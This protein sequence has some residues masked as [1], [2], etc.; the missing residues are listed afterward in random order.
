MIR[1]LIAIIVDWHVYSLRVKAERERWETTN[2]S[3][4][5]VWE[6]TIFSFKESSFE[7]LVRSPYL[8]RRPKSAIAKISSIS[9]VLN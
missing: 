7:K 6:H 8:T 4:F 1:Y 3:M 5:W 2:V 9:L